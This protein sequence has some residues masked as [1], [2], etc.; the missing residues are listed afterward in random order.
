MSRSDLQTSCRR[1][2]TWHCVRLWHGRLA[3]GITGKMPVPRVPCAKSFSENTHRTPAGIRMSEVKFIS[4][5]R[6]SELQALPTLAWR[7]PRFEGFR[8]RSG[9]GSGLRLDATM[10]ETTIGTTI[11]YRGRASIVMIPGVEVAIRWIML[12]HCP[13]RCPDP[14]RSSSSSR[15]LSRSSSFFIFVTSFVASFVASFVVRNSS[16]HSPY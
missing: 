13:D 3:H 10:I 12:H 8:R 11:G 16:A 14:R 4:H 2:M 5:A 7:D 6:Y 9:Q 15:S 1:K